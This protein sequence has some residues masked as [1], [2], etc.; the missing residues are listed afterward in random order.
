[1]SLCWGSN[2][3]VVKVAIA[4]IPPLAFNALR[5]FIASVL[6]LVA[7]NV[8]PRLSGRHVHRL[9]R[10]D[11]VWMFALGVVGHFF[12]QL[13]F[14]GG[15]ARTTVANSSLIIGCS[16]VVV[17][18]VTAAIG[19]ERVSRVHWAGATLSIVGIY[20]IVGRGASVSEGALAGDLL[21]LCA[22]GC[23]TFYTVASRPLL[24]RNSP[25]VVTGY[26]MAFGTL[27]YVPLGAR[28]LYG[29]DWS[30]IGIDT[31]AAVM[32]SAVFALYLAY[33]IWYT[34]VQRIG[35]VRTSIY[36]NMVP[37]V[38]MAIAA[39]WLGE[40]LAP[41]QVAG[42]AAIIGGVGLTRLAGLARKA[43]PAEE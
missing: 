24:A 2:F 35:N 26:S 18:I 33:W 15:L 6:F 4:H 40:R 41:A 14:L 25:L 32:F 34:A 21:T 5:L 43:P 3:S 1:M 7:I 23:W 36:S 10:S 11:W 28:D 31:W 19:Q 20:L 29:V 37:V 8:I 30:S 13:F 9:S 22:V 39:V 42:A 12:Y 27:L 16:P 17:A 38:A